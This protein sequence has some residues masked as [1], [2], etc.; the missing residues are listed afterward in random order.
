MRLSVLEFNKAIKNPTI[1]TINDAAHTNANIGLIN[2]FNNAIKKDNMSSIN[3]G[4][5]N[6]INPN[7]NGSKLKSFI[8]LPI[9]VNPNLK[10]LNHVLFHRA[11]C[12][13]N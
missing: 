9:N 12:F 10:Y 2:I 7:T 5:L 11:R 3:N 4:G 8:P 6:K 1:K 13:T